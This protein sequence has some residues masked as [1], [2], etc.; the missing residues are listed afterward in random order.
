MPDDQRIGAT[1]PRLEGKLTGRPT[2]GI[3]H[4]VKNNYRS[5]T[6]AVPIGGLLSVLFSREKNRRAS[7]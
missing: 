3:R 6:G 2:E 5:R 7:S 4:G 1:D